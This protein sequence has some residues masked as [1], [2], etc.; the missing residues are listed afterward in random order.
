MQASATYRRFRS[1]LCRL[2]VQGDMMCNVTLAYAGAY[3]GVIGQSLEAR[4][5]Q[6]DS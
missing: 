5:S 1:G 4:S 3:E 2:G 6:A